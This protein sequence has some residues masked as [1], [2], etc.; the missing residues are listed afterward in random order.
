MIIVSV[1]LRTKINNRLFCEK[2]IFHDYRS[3]LLGSMVLLRGLLTHDFLN[4]FSGLI[5]EHIVFP[6][7][8]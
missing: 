2:L 1:N 7:F 6:V 4:S 3:L 8:F 5:G